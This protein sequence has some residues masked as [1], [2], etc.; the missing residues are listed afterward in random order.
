MRILF[1]EETEGLQE[2]GKAVFSEGP[3]AFPFLPRSF[4]H[5]DEGSDEL[6]AADAFHSLGGRPMQLILDDGSHV[7]ERERPGVI[8]TTDVL[9]GDLDRSIA[10][11]LAK[12]GGHGVGNGDQRSPIVLGAIVERFRQRRVSVSQG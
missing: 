4:I 7:G 11:G 6:V 2:T 3:A 12:I 1:G 8:F 5:R 10:S 9:R